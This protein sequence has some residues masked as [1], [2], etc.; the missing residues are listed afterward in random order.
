[1]WGTVKDEVLRAHPR[2]SDIFERQEFAPQGL[3]S[4]SCAA[5]LRLAA[6]FR[7][8]VF[9]KPST[10]LAI[11]AQGNIRLHLVAAP[12]HTLDKSR[13]RAS[14]RNMSAWVWALGLGATAFFVRLPIPPY[15]LKEG[16]KG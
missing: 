9:Q 5:L 2:P 4:L 6:R 12:N 1:V 8:Q 16:Q 7:A 15:T 10:T 14:E 13:L 11:I 3:P